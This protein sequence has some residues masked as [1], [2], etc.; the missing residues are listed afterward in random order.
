MTWLFVLIAWTVCAGVAA[1]VVGRVLA[2][3]G[4]VDH[5]A[6]RRPVPTP[7]NPLVLR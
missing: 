2:Y 4:L 6:D 5:P 7:R 1:P 3:G